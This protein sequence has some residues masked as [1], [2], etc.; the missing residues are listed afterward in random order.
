[1]DI[2][3]QIKGC[4][5]CELRKL[6]P[7]TCEPV[8][9]CG[10]INS[11]LW[12]IAESPGEDEVLVGEPLVGMAGKFFNKLLKAA[13]INR[14]DCWLDNVIHCRC[15]NDGK[16]NRPPSW[17]ELTT[18][19]DWIVELIKQSSPKV[20]IAMGKYSVYTL[21]EGKVKKTFTLGPM[22]G[23]LYDVSYSSAKIIP[24]LHPSYLL[25]YS[26]ESTQ[27]TIDIFKMAKVISGI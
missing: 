12:F 18:C 16:K 7:E 26:K 11:P 22:C 21:L 4:Q 13:D 8:V 6:I 17:N 1:M 5:K 10:D 14:E 9:G 24:A 15:T 27:K 20:V 2:L 19:K 3:E 25:Q 23:Q